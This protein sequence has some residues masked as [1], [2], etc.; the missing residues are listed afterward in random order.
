MKI[1]LHAGTDLVM[2]LDS[3]WNKRE[4]LFDDLERSMPRA[5][6][7][8]V[9]GKNI[10][11]VYVLNGPWSFTLLRI[12]AI[13]IN[14][15]Q[16]VL[17]TTIISIPKFSL[18]QYLMEK[19]YVPTT[20]VVFTGQ[21]KK[22]F[23]LEQGQSEIDAL[24]S[25]NHEDWLPSQ[26]AWNYRI[27]MLTDH[28]VLALLDPWMMITYDHVNETGLYLSY[29]WSEIIIAL[30]ELDQRWMQVDHLE[31]HYVQAAL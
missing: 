4:V 7:A 16:D 3:S 20:W 23:V 21:R 24:V 12:V 22:L 27:Q 15:T 29:A 30:S 31:P 8:F 1:F 17:Q 19:E 6:A 18:Y 10:D 9:K 11:T 13:C 5:W 25:F 28:P 2:M 14:L 26:L